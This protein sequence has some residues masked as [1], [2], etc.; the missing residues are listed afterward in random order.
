MIEI[1]RPDALLRKLLPP[2]RP[3]TGMVYV[4]S[5]FVLSFEHRG[6]SF[7]YNTL[8]KQV[9]GGTLPERALAGEGPTLLECKTY[10]WRG[11]WTGDP[12]VYRTRQDVED[13]K[14]NRDPIKLFAEYMKKNKLASAA[15][16]KKIQDECAEEMA[17]AVEFAENS[18]QPDP[19]HVTDDVFFEG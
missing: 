7:L 2:Q 1:Q 19:A 4:P 8:T 11:H 14:E 13:W 16:L 6:R 5:R 12:E 17:K 9:I 10:R 3:Q 18:P 15:A